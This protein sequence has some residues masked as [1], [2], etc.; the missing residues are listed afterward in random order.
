MFIERSFH[1]CNLRKSYGFHL[2]SQGGD[3]IPS[4]SDA[5]GPYR[6]KLFKSERDILFAINDNGSS[7]SR[8]RQFKRIFDFEK[9]KKGWVLLIWGIYARM[10]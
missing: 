9:S 3:P 6:M 2:V 7:N 4:V 8:I 10:N 1:T 5:K